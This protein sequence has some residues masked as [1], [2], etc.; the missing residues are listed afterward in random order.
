M[1]FTETEDVLGLLCGCLGDRLRAKMNTALA[2][3]AEKMRAREGMLA[4][5]AAS[6]A[7]DL[8]FAGNMVANGGAVAAF[9][10]LS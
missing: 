4:A 6:I 2:E 10:N 5:R 3:L 8:V 9:S 7:G 1:A